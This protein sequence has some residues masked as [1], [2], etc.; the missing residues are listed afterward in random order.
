MVIECEK[1]QHQLTLEVDN[2]KQ[3]RIIIKGLR[4]NFKYLQCPNCN[5]IYKIFI[6]D[7][8]MEL[9]QKE[10]EDIREQINKNHGT[11]NFLK[12]EI[13]YEKLKNKQREI[14]IHYQRLN[15]RLKGKFIYKDGKIEYIEEK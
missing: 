6:E 10:L 5:A 2:I 4:Y 14:R 9:L 7:K 11:F 3:K 12:A 13:L 15:E 1:C 8:K